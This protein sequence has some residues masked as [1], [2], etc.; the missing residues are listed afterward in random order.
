MYLFTRQAQLAV[1]Q[2]RPGLEWAI[3]ITEKVNQITS[4]DVG[5]WSP[6]LSPGL[7]TLSWGAAVE[8]LGD[9]EDAEAKLNAD[10]M[11][12]D[13]LERGAAFITGGVDDQVAQFISNPDSDPNTNHVAVV[14]SQIANG[15]FGRGVEV[16]VAIAEKATE[17]GGLP[18]AFLLATTGGYA[19]CAWITS[20]TSLRALEAGEQKVNADPGFVAFLDQEAATCYVEGITTQSIWRRV[21]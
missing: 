20:A 9:L 6:T 19:A 4:L 14:Q 12:L 8:S 18:T 17:I 13:A 1:G 2:Q 3:G 10:P 15:A 5:L 7:G 16:G 21:V 11:Y